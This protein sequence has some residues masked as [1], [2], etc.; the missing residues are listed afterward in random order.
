MAMN[1][2]LGL[3][4]QSPLKPLQKH[5]KKVTECC[6]LLVPF[7]QASFEQDW[8][9]AEEIRRQIT[10]LE[11]RADLLKREIR[12]KS[13]RGLFMPVDR[14]D[15]LELVTQLDKLANFSKD[16]SGRI[17]GRQLII[18]TETQATFMHFLSRS[19]DATVQVGK[20]ISE[21]DHLLE[22]GFRGRE[23]NFVNTMITELDTIEDDTD[24]LQIMLRKAIF[25]IEDQHNPIDIMILYKIIEWVGVLADQAQRIGS[26]IEL[27]LA[28][29]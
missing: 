3:F 27:M 4:A 6:G 19:L 17:I 5:A 28:R 11:H 10:D 15:L 8:E 22:T 14:S 13:P 20:V 1:N 9:K 25:S 23:L 29:S 26:R 2:I 12:L 21:M 18:P 16:I 24:Q 7:F